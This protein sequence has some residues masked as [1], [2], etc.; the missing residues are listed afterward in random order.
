MAKPAMRNET[1]G[2]RLLQALLAFKILASE[3]KEGDTIRVERG[4]EGL[5]FSS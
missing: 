3:F 1:A 2:M 5:I 4:G